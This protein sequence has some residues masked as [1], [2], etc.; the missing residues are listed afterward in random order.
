[1]TDGLY[2][3]SL[4][5]AGE[6][7]M[8]LNLYGY[9]P[10][11]RQKWIIVDMGVTFGDDTVPGIDLIMADPDFIVER[12]E[13]LLGI[14][15]THAHE[16]HI[17]A[18]A[19][20]WPDL[21]CPIY[22]TK[23]T[24]CMLRSK[25][26]EAGLVRDAR[27]TVVPLE[28]RLKIGPFDITY[29]TL[30][31]S[32]PEPNALAIRTPLGNILH[33]G[34]WKIDPDPLLG[35]AT[36]IAGLTGFGDEGVL[37]M[38]CDS[39]NVFSPGRAGS[40]AAVKS[41]LSTLLSGMKGRVAVTAFASNV[42]RVDSIGKAAAA[43]GRQ[44]VLVGRSMH[45]VVASAR[46]AGYLK[47]FPPVL[48]ED[49]AASLH[50]DQVLYICTGSQGEAR[51]ALSRIAYG[52][53]PRIGL[54]SGDTVIFS[55]RIIPGNER[56]IFRLQNRLAERGVS[57]ITE[58]DHFVHV[59]GHPCRD[60]LADMYAWVRPEISVP[61]HGEIRHM[62]EHVKLAQDIQVP[63]TILA[64]NGS[65]VQLAPGRACIVEE[66]YTGRLY[67]DGD[68]LTPVDD[69]QVNE[70]LKLSSAGHLGVMLV[71]DKD[72]RLAA[73]PRVTAFGLPTE[74]GQLINLRKD[75]AEAVEEAVAKLRG[76]QARDDDM[77]REAALRAA[78]RAVKESTGKKPV[79]QVEV[80][81]L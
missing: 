10:K 5:G 16:D 53:H 25:L 27:V 7:G 51:A 60:E 20:L 57:V 50:P 43:H 45:K 9:G 11:D 19:H 6:I 14:V 62:M 13:D 64:P 39:T 69:G 21:R 2:F 70:R 42:A 79:T 1:M 26:E 28:G 18:V 23:F 75:V 78:R 38:V 32:I 55:S 33:T 34:D 63:Q 66:V 8:N 36:D 74:D 49:D 77:V 61:V 73:E 72:G 22:A 31:H 30:T 37:A 35:D 48:R 17:G 46:E 81:R 29:V 54:G 52:D 76:K 71:V 68:V 12:R 65:L 40:E 44:I 47:D 24:A 41:S 67:L 80:I 15:L 3:L 4:G 58:K 59:S 56:S